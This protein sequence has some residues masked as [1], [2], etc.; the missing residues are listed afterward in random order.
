MRKVFFAVGLEGQQ[1]RGYLKADGT[2]A[3]GFV[4]GH[5]A[6]DHLLTE[7]RAKV[8]AAANAY[9]NG[10]PRKLSKREDPFGRGVQPRTVRIGYAI[11]A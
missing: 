2:V 1:D 4:T 9:L 5:A 11:T 10:K 8:E 3:K 6:A 7:D